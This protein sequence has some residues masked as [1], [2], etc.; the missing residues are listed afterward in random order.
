MRG[1]RGSS[2]GWVGCNRGAAA[3]QS[4]T[5]GAK[6]ARLRCGGGAGGEGDVVPGDVMLGGICRS[7]DAVRARGG[8]A[9]RGVDSRA[10][11]EARALRVRGAV[12]GHGHGRGR[13]AVSPARH[14]S[15]A[16]APAP[17]RHAAPPS[18]AAGL[19]NA[20]RAPLASHFAV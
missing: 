8:T 19:Q 20:S 6:A 1:R 13:D 5:R 7:S 11:D 2:R 17:R 16:A 3:K 14:R 10:R 15:P 4:G 18:P 12:T 9:W